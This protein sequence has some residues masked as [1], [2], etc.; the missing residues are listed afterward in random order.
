[1]IPG[2]QYLGSV[3]FGAVLLHVLA[4]SNKPGVAFT[5]VLALCFAWAGA[6]VGE[7]AIGS[8]TAFLWA[9]TFTVAALLMAALAVTAYGVLR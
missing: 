9:V 4:L 8:K 6:Y 1:M 7:L 5:A 3:I 2:Y